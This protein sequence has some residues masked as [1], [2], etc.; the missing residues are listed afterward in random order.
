MCLSYICWLLFQGYIPPSVAGNTTGPNSVVGATQYPYPGVPQ[1]GYFPPRPGYNFPRGPPGSYD[2]TT[3]LPP[4]PYG[5][6]FPPGPSNNTHYGS[7]ATAGARGN[8]SR[9]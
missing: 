8:P 3:R 9:R 7:A 1:P 6:P 2:P 5:A 4:G